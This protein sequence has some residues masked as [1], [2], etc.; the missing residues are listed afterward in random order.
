MATRE[1]IIFIMKKMGEL[2]SQRR[3]SDFN[4]TQ[5]GIGAVM[6][7]LNDTDGEITAGRISEELGISTARVAALLKKMEAKNLIIREHCKADKRVTVVRL[8]QNGKDLIKKIKEQMYRKA[9]ELIDTIGEKRLMEF[10]ETS[11]QICRIMRHELK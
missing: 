5:E 6:R 7:L 2:H 11:E 10:I 1:Q 3:I 9:N 8:T 4:E